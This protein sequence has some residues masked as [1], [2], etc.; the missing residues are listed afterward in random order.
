MTEPLGFFLTWTTYGGWVPG[1]A[2]GW[3]SRGH[4]LR[5]PDHRLEAIVQRKLNEL[6]LLLSDQ[7]RLIVNET[8]KS[9]CV[10]RGWRLWA[11]N[12]RTNHVHVVVTANVRPEL[13]MNQF[14]AWCTRRLK[15]SAA[16][17]D[18][19]NW[20]TKSGSTRYITRED[21]LE[22]AI[23]YTLEAQDRKGLD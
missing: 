16:D 10:F 17:V 11:V 5:E 7:A 14:K 12:A 6:P 3:T 20:W 4:G 18:R 9:H 8:I 22:S 23:I 1:D 2:R 13:V 19:D 15:E 21:N